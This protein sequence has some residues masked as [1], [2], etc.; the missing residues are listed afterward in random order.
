MFHAVTPPLL[1]ADLLAQVAA[2]LLHC[3]AILSRIEHSVHAVIDSHPASS[4]TRSWQRNL[5][6]ID[7]LAQQLGDL[8]R[9][10]TATAAE[11]AVKE[12]RA[13]SILQV[14][15]DLTLDDLRQRLLGQSDALSKSLEVEFF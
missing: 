8:A 14:M 12:A 15:G 3:K 5:Q 2:E 11:P 7:L 4:E 6:D 1:P 10:L 13:L 9:C